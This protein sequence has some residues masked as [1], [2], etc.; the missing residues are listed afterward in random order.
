VDASGVASGEEGEEREEVR[1]GA[2][3]TAETV[4]TTVRTARGPT[5]AA[6]T[7]RPLLLRSGDREVRLSGKIDRIDRTVDGHALVFDYKLGKARP[8]RET[9]E[10]RSLQMPI[11]WLAVEQ[12]LGLTVVG[13]GYDALR[14]G[15]RPIIARCDL[16]G[17]AFSHKG[18]LGKNA[19]GRGPFEQIK[20]Q[21][22]AAVFA[23]VALI[24]QLESAPA[25]ADDR[26]CS[27]CPYQDCC[28]P[29]EAGVAFGREAEGREDE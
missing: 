17:H 23:A 16:A 12:L 5:D 24:E 28:R 8:V 26:T 4:P 9:Q 6:S 27:F 20:E 22:Q 2:V 29:E 10:G 13:G 15:Q 18:I 1:R 21:V 14:Q 7:P 25:P 19:L 11:Y 3:P